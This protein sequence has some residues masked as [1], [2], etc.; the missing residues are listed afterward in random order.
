MISLHISHRIYAYKRSR[1]ILD[2]FLLTSLGIGKL[3][4]EGIKQQQQ[5]AVDRSSEDYST[6]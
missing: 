2:G 6:M 4:E 5:E 1:N 3:N